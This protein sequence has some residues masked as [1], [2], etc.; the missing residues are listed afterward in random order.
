M[1]YIGKYDELAPGRGFDSM[2]NHFE[3]SE[4]PGKDKIVEYLKTGIIDMVS[5]EAAH[6]VFT[7]EKIPLEKLGMNDGKFIWWN[8]LSHYVEKYNLRL[9][10]EFE[11]H[12]LQ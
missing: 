8:T 2:K 12:I 7:G 5:A 6:D 10:Q 11:Q 4:Y 9:P 3:K 1:I